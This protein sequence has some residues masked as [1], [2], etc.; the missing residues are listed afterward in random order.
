VRIIGRIHR[1]EFD[2]KLDGL[3]SKA[4]IIAKSTA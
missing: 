4:Y 2:I 1:R 3:E